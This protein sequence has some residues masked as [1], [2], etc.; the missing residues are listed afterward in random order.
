MHL[1]DH[2]L[3]CYCRLPLLIFHNKSRLQLYSLKEHSVNLDCIRRWFFLILTNTFLFWYNMQYIR[4][5]IF[6]LLRYFLQ[7]ILLQIDWSYFAPYFPRTIL[8]ST[9]PLLSTYLRR[10]RFILDNWGG[11]GLPLSILFSIS[12]FLLPGWEKLKWY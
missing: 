8:C 9:Y 11:E 5:S 7:L 12:F 10:L 6:F 2:F 1:L 3:K 4:L